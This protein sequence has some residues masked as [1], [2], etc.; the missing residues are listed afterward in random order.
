[1]SAVSLVPCASKVDRFSRGCRASFVS[2]SRVSCCLVCRRPSLPVAVVCR[3]RRLVCRRLVFVL[4][5]VLVSSW[6]PV[7]VGHAVFLRVCEVLRLCTSAGA[8]AFLS[9]GASSLVRAGLGMG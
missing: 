4:S 1:M 6:L 9:T 2:C 8:Y 7:G 5:F 3:R